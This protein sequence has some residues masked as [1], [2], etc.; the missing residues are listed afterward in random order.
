MAAYIHTCTASLGDSVGLSFSAVDNDYWVKMCYI[1]LSLLLV[2]RPSAIISVGGRLMQRAWG[3]G[4]IVLKQIIHT[5]TRTYILL[6]VVFLSGSRAC[7][8]DPFCK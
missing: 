1:I 5:H 6:R 2:P 4:Y 8:V 3:R 7:S